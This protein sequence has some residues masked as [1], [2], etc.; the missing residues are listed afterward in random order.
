MLDL[1]VVHDFCF[2]L[3]Y[4]TI[5]VAVAARGCKEGDGGL[6]R[7]VVQ[8]V[9]VADLA[10]VGDRGRCGRSK[11]QSAGSVRWHAE[12]LPGDISMA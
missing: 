6:L 4:I 11:G 9:E 5:V 1:V 8:A 2:Q 3:S 12:Q 10:G 7:R